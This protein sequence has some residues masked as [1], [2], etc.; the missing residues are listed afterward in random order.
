MSSRSAPRDRD[1]A[2]VVAL[3]GAR[4]ANRSRPVAS[5]SVSLT[6]RQV[7]GEVSAVVDALVGD[8]WLADRELLDELATRLVTAG[9]TLQSMLR[10]VEK[11]SLHTWCV[12]AHAD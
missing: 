11:S 1:A 2:P 7:D 10:I 8:N 9:Y 5:S 6:P 3:P 12:T 4:P